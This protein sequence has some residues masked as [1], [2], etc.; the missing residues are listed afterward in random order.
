MREAAR[1]RGRLAGRVT[2][3]APICSM[4]DSSLT[5]S[6]TLKPRPQLRQYTALAAASGARVRAHAV[7]GMSGGRAWMIFCGWGNRDRRD[8]GVGGGG[9]SVVFSIP[10]RGGGSW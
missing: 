3:S 1:G 8:R 2:S 6:E 10:G 7:A 4:D 9:L 5:C